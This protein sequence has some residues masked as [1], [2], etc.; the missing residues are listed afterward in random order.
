M[1]PVDINIRQFLA[2]KLEAF[3]DRGEGVYFSHDLEDVV[4]ILENRD[5]VIL[6]MMDS[7]SELKAYFSAQAQSLLNEGFLN[8]LP[9]LLNDSNSAETIESYL[10]IISSW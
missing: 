4:F 5:G 2:T 9:G 7:S 3:A 8:V 10:K 6:E 1:Q